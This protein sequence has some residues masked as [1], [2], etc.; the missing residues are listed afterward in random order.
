MKYLIALLLSCLPLCAATTL[1]PLKTDSTSQVI[2][3]GGT[4]VALLNGTNNFTGP[5]ILTNA[6]STLAGDGSA[7]T[8]IGVRLI[9]SSPTNIYLDSLSTTAASTLTNNGGWSGGTYVARITC[10]ALRSSNAI[11][12]LVMH[13]TTTNANTTAGTLYAYAGQNTN[14][15][16]NGQFLQASLNARTTFSLNASLFVNYGSYTNQFIGGLLQGTPVVNGVT[17]LVDTSVPFDIYV[18]L[19]TTTGFTNGMLSKVRVYAI[20]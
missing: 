16:G 13:S 5:V 7:I 6:A 19:A 9:G 20:E 18:C 1:Y 11:V 2:Y 17:N 3:G 4:N 12:H 14:Y 15:V 8:G 10:S